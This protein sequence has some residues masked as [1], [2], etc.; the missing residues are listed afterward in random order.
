PRL[1]H[2]WAA[3]AAGYSAAGDPTLGSDA[4]RHVLAPEPQR[5]DSAVELADLYNRQAR[6]A[7]ARQV[8][9]VAT[10]AQKNNPT[11]WLALSRIEEQQ[12][13]AIGAESAYRKAV[14]AESTTETNR[15]LAQFLQRT[16][17][18][19][20]AE[21]VLQQLDSLHV[22]L[23]A[24]AAD[25]ALASGHPDR[26]LK[27][28]DEA[29]SPA[30]QVRQATADDEKREALARLAARKIEAQLGD[31]IV[32]DAAPSTEASDAAMRSQA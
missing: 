24:S 20:E 17:R 7:E 13:N 30:S 1:P 6:I 15:R 4:R 16:S 25:F 23:P 22:G 29:L 31:G 26:A 19:A 3:L 8:L 12:G 27:R 14:A 28:Y 9:L 32:T 10:E 2:A 21:F 5:V 18:V 11:A